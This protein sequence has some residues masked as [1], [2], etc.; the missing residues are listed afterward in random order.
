MSNHEQQPVA[1]GDAALVDEKAERLRRFRGPVIARDA[2]T[3]AYWRDASATEHARAM[4]E[5]SE[6]A[7]IMVRQTG[8]GKDPG[9][10]FPGFPS[11]TQAGEGSP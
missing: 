1:E 7:A 3:V 8:Y 6:F 9:E 10:M 11:L 2:E 4:I 5:L